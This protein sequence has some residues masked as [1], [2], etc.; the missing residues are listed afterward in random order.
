MRDCNWCSGA[1][2]LAGLWLLVAGCGPESSSNEGDRTSSP[3]S[4][5]EFVGERA[6]LRAEVD[7]RAKHEVCEGRPPAGEE[8]RSPEECLQE[9]TGGW[10]RLEDVEERFGG[11]AERRRALEAGTLG[12]DQRAAV[13]CLAGLRSYVGQLSCTQARRMRGL[14][15]RG[16]LEREIIPGCAEVF[17]PR[18]GEGDRCASSMECGGELTCSARE[19][20]GVCGKC[21]PAVDG[22]TGGN[23]GLEFARKGELCA[24]PDHSPTCDPTEPLVCDQSG[25]SEWRCVEERS[26]EEG[27][28]CGRNAGCAG[29]LVCQEGTCTSFEVV[30]EGES[31][32]SGTAY[33][34]S[35][36]VCGVTS[37]GEEVCAE[38]GAEGD[39]CR[40]ANHCRGELFC[41]SE[42]FRD[43]VGNCEPPLEEG[44]SC[45]YNDTCT[46][47]LRC[48][49][50][51]GE[52]RE[53]RGRVGEGEKCHER[54]DC[55][56]GLICRWTGRGREC[57]SRD[58]NKT[59]SEET[60]CRGSE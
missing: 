3:P 40:N 56:E 24:S 52:G 2:V 59:Q 36:Y 42:G 35:P 18:G 49:Y 51:S 53:C 8:G 27:E 28:T 12:F 34:E 37:D 54:L 21:R 29:G 5:E 14:I 32:E 9:T 26:K 4:H 58:E 19:S 43:D 17:E 25:A 6:E 7:C 50:R 22:G 46:G 33:C 48:I 45:D 10:E 16:A 1:A 60:S 20:D 44:E 11:S 23:D 41:H 57:T 55:Q 47:D 31:C 15:L 13:D 30:G 38:E 39:P